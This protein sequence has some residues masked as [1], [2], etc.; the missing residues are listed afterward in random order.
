MI[1][2]YVLHHDDD[3]RIRWNQFT[4]L[5]IGGYAAASVRLEI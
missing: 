1:P 5:T 4:E 2:I 3:I